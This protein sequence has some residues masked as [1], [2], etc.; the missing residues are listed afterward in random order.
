MFSVHK[1]PFDCRC[2]PGM[3]H[4]PYSVWTARKKERNGL[5]RIKQENESNGPGKTQ[6]RGRPFGEMKTR[7]L[8]IYGNYMLLTN[9]E[10]ILRGTE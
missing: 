8:M 7:S 6:P 10:L 2:S 1:N 9:T 3:F 4:L 5:I